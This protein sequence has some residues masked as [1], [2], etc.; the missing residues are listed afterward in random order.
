MSIKNKILVIVGLSTIFLFVIIFSASQ[1]VFTRSFSKL[2]TDDA[3]QNIQRTHNALNA[4]IE[5]LDTLLRDWSS[6]DSCYEF[7]LEPNQEFID[8]NLGGSTVVNLKLNMFI[9]V[10]ARGEVLMI[11]GADIQNGNDVTIPDSTVAILKNSNLLNQSDIESSSCGLLDLEGVPLLFAS[12]PIL[13]SNDEGPVAGTVL[14]GRYLNDAMINTL[15]ETVHLPL[16]ISDINSQGLSSDLAAAKERLAT[17]P[18]DFIAIRD[19][20]TIAGYSIVSDINGNPISVLKIELPRV[21]YSQGQSSLN[22]FL[23]LIG[24]L[25]VLFMIVVVIVV[26]R[27]ISQSQKHQAE[28]TR[29]SKINTNLVTEL[30]NNARELSEASQHLTTAANYSKESSKQVAVSSQQMAKGAQEQSLNAQNTA[31][32]M[33]EMSEAITHLSNSARE[34]SIEVEKAINSISRLSDGVAKVAENAMIAKQVSVDGDKAVQTAKEKTLQTLLGMDKIKQ[35]NAQSTQ[36]IE[37]LGRR[38][39]EIGKIVSVIGDIAEQTNL[40]ALNAAIEAARAGEQGR[41]FAVVSD[42]VRK[43]AERTSA[44]TKEIAELIGNVQSDVDETTRI[45][46]GGNQAVNEGYQ[47]AEQAKE[48]IN[49]MIESTNQVHRQIENINIKTQEINNFSMELVKLVNKV[50]DITSRHSKTAQTMTASTVQVSQSMETM[51]GIAEQNSAA[52]QEMSASADE[53]SHQV[54]E[55]VTSSSNL[56]EMAHRLSEDISKFKAESIDRSGEFNTKKQQSTR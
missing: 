29:I 19:S 37:V 7:A 43:L 31:K 38:S 35:T 10:N 45:I 53:I 52:T 55:I 51:A 27:L 48:S 44:A 24:G 54:E 20:N 4:S 2:E 49:Q 40:L 36:K 39:S 9:I 11:K 26:F 28:R 17:N 23:V 21:I 1:I 32:S 47:V 34:Q 18:E 42:E 41:G 8:D 56:K 12:R 13:T 3:L 15:A 6:W 33:E 30:A 14:M 46:L 25:I 5:S 22:K 16:T 50:G